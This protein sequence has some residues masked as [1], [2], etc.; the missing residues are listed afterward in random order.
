MGETLRNKVLRRFM[1][2]DR[3]R[4]SRVRR[5]FAAAKNRVA[6]SLLVSGHNG[7][8]L[9]QARP[10]HEASAEK[11]P[12]TEKRNTIRPRSVPSPSPSI[13]WPVLH[14]GL[15]GQVPGNAGLRD[16]VGHCISTAKLVG[17]LAASLLLTNWPLS[18]RRL[19]SRE[20]DSEFPG[21]FLR[22]RTSFASIL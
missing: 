2:R 22:I 9:S 21:L 4:S 10:R 11:W 15:R 20:S 18:C 8:L 13:F 3:S 14:P 6:G 12:E 7:D 1:A 16:S 17:W 19:L 5:L